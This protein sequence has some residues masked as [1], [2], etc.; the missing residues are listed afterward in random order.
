M[1]E[2]VEERRLAPV[3]IVEHCDEG[4]FGCDVFEQLADVPEQLV[5][6]YSSFGD[7]GDRLLGAVAELL[8]RLDYRPER[9]PVAV[10]QAAAADHG[11]IDAGEKL[12]HQPR[13]ADAGCAEEREQ[14]ART[15]AGGAFVRLLKQREL[16]LARDKRRVLTSGVRRRLRVDAE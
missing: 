16:P 15:F 10:V 6:R 5:G 4:T 9:D 11:R 3:Q 1:V 8:Q 2:K 14:I 13:F 12:G 7:A